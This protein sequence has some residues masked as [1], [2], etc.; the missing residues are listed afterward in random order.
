MSKVHSDYLLTHRYRTAMQSLQELALTLVYTEKNRDLKGVLSRQRLPRL[1]K[2]TL[3]LSRPP[4]PTSKFK[5]L[6]PA[7]TLLDDLGLFDLTDLRTLSLKLGEDGHRYGPIVLGNDDAQRFGCLSGL[8]ELDIDIPIVF[9]ES[10]DFARDA[11]LTALPG[12]LTAL[13]WCGEVF[14]CDEFNSWKAS[15]WLSDPRRRG[16]NEAG[17]LR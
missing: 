14:D 13:I 3:Y 4:T 2:L 1:R 16:H 12:T 7:T 15:S 5:M 11:L 8:I 10:N 17:E 6:P 9:V